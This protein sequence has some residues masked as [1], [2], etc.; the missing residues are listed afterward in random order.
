MLEVTRG[1]VVESVHFGAAAVVDIHGRLLAHFGDAHTTTYLRSSAKP[2]Q[3]LPLI[4][5]G[6]PEAFG[7]TEREIAV[8]CASHHGSDEHVAVVRSIQAK[9][10][11]AESDLLCGSHDPARATLKMMILRGE[12]PSPIRH[13]CSGKHTGML[14]QARLHNLSWE[15]YINPS[16]PVQQLNLKTFA[17]LTGQNVAEI[18]LGTDGCSAPVYAVPLCHAALAF[19]RLSDPS[20]LEERRAAAC[21]RIVQAM[22]TNPDMVQGEGGFDTVL[23]E[24]GGGRMFTKGGAEGYQAIG[25]LPG[26]VYAG[27][28]GIGITLKIADGDH[29]GRARPVAA[30]EMLRQ[31]GVFSDEQ[32]K[33]VPRYSNRVVSNWRKLDVGELR[34][35]F[36]LRRTQ[37]VI[38]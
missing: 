20:L 1:A 17:E 18:V 37:E 29:S 4:E 23:M 35:V 19:A 36:T 6:G 34:P 33:A 8:I 12:E 24:F 31:L 3:A 10:N 21:R 5:M 2:I 25:L 30:I 9:I 11:A 13:N 22:I 27:S 16:H 38:S 15:D 14:A 28:P 32:A 7:L 26:A